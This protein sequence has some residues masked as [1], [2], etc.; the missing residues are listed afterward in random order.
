MN[1]PVLGVNIDHICTLRNVRGI[2]Y[3]DPMQLAFIAE[4]RGVQNITVHLR[5]D[6]RHIQDTDVRLLRSMM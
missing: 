5:M 1:L 3:P 6:R 2:N 4:S